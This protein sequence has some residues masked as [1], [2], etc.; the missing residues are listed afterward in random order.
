MGSPLPFAQKAAE[1]L[2]LEHAWGGR[3]VECVQLATTESPR[4][5]FM[6]SDRIEYSAQLLLLPLLLGLQGLQLFSLWHQRHHIFFA[7]AP[8]GIRTEQKNNII[9]YLRA[10]C[11]ESFC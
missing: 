6:S 10:G 4:H 3:R 11:E 8:R 5:G 2:F 7:V 1:P 9:I